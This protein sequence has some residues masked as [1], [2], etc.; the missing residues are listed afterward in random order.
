MPL[1]SK[2]PTYRALEILPGALVWITFI[3]IFLCSWLKPLWAIYFIILFDLYWLIRILYM[4]IF[5]FSSW[6]RF[7][8]DSKINWLERC[9]KLSHWRD[10]YHLVVLVTYKEPLEV[11]E[12][13]FANLARTNF[14]LDRFIVVLAGE[15]RDKD[16]FLKIAGQIKEKFGNKF[17][18][19]L[20]TVHPKNLANEI[21]GKGSNECWAGKRVREEVIDRLGL[22]YEKI[23]VSTFDID[24]CPHPE[25]FGCLTYKYLT[26]PHPTRTSFQP[27]AIFNNNIWV[28]PALTRVVSRGTTFWILTE[29]AN[30][31]K[32]FF[33]FSSH[34]MSFKAL[35]EI[36]FWQKDIVTEDSR[37]FMQCQVHYKGQYW[38]VPLFVPI[39]MDTVYAGSFWKTMVNQYKQML[40]WGYSAEHVPYAIWYYLIKKALPF[41]KAIR[42]IWYQMESAYSWA[43]API[44]IVVLGYLPLWLAGEKVKA[45]VTL[46]NAPFVLE[47]IMTVAMVG[48]LFCGILS[49][50][51]LPPRP[52]G[53]PWYAYIF[54]ALQWIL[55]PIT[56]IVFGS[57]PAIE[58]ETRL[59]LGK[60][61]GFRVTEKRR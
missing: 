14:P 58:A 56:M 44:L 33:T 49:M 16:N 13:T 52:K 32:G 54:M 8:R 51:L 31:E 42:Y 11:I 40:R 5:L 3:G 46:Q 60:Y 47:K 36:G 43:V 30:P 21:P 37:I 22:S 6:R 4:L 17:F 24:S 48:L 15:E 34:S 25:Y 1:L 50:F 35:V 20:I 41:W 38:R 9:K 29:L 2:N 27:V 28:S 23:V 12:P 7:R 39:S 45:T 19:F 10:I 53:H 57:I 18:K 55:F 59:M 26:V 61:L